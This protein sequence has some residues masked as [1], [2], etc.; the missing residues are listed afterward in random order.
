MMSTSASVGRAGK[1][2]F[3]FWNYKIL[4][5]FGRIKQVRV[6]SLNLYLPIEMVENNPLHW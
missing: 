4:N 6:I 2:T 5:D 3:I 1:R